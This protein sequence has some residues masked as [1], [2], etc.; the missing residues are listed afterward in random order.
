MGCIENKSAP[1]AGDSKSG[2]DFNPFEIMEPRPPSKTPVDR[3]NGK[4]V[5]ANDI[6]PKAY[7]CP[8]IITWRRT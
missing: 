5:K 7:T 1:A 8:T 2:K 4:H 3:K 6:P